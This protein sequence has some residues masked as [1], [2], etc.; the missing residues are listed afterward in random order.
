MRADTYPKGPFRAITTNDLGTEANTVSTRIACSCLCACA[1]RKR[2]RE[3]EQGRARAQAIREILSARARV[4][5]AEKRAAAAFGVARGQMP[6]HAAA[7]HGHLEAVGMLLQARASAR[8]QN[9]ISRSTP[10]C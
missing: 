5:C 2:E 4:D 3:L 1:E 8:A 10:R 6:I 9:Q 7:W